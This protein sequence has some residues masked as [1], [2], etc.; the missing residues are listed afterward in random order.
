MAIRISLESLFS[1]ASAC[2]LSIFMLQLRAA[3]WSNKQIFCG[4]PPIVCRSSRAMGLDRHTAQYAYLNES[5]LQ[6]DIGYFLHTYH[7]DLSCTIITHTRLFGIL[8]C[9]EK[10]RCRDSWQMADIYLQLP[11]HTNKVF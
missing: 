6:G 5:S 10:R 8:I 2:A 9:K 3:W 1:C 11:S 7:N 4:L